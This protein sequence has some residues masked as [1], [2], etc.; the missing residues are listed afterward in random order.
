MVWVG[1]GEES[2]WWSGAIGAEWATPPTVQGGCSC[3]S[4]EASGD[5]T[6]KVYDVRQARSKAGT[7]QGRRGARQPRSE[8]RHH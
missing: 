5:E 7:E 4:P 8:V 3:S 6:A 2:G 1:L